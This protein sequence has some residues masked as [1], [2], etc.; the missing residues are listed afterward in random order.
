MNVDTE[1]DYQTKDKG[2][3]ISGLKEDDNTG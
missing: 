1:N 2:K 3:M